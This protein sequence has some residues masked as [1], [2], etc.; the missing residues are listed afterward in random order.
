[1]IK[2]EIWEVRDDRTL[3]PDDGGYRHILLGRGEE[4]VQIKTKFHK[5]ISE[6]EGV[7]IMSSG[8]WSSITEADILVTLPNGEED[9]R[10]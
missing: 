3:Y 9:I 6:A 10:E 7:H 4:R 1:M 2:K 8:P 5:E